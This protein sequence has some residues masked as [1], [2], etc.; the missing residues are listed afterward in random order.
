MCFL[1]P[2]RPL[3]AVT[4]PLTASRSWALSAWVKQEDMT[5]DQLEI[6]KI[7]NKWNEVRM[8]DRDEAEKTLDKEWLEAY[9]RYF[10]KYD[11]DMTKM[12][13][14]AA[15]LGT[16]LEPPRLEKK[17][18]GQR[19]RDAYAKKLARQAGREATAAKLVKQVK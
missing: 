19:K 18:K 2:Y 15:K 6:V 16:M 1:F 5:P 17:T 7:T 13:D 11:S 14:I 10:E 9:N 3:I 8:L 4:A 12:L